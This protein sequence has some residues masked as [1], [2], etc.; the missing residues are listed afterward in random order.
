MKIFIFLNVHTAEEEETPKNAGT[1]FPL[2][3]MWRRKYSRERIDME[4]GN[5]HHELIS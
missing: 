5:L 2:R 4:N 1:L 3:A